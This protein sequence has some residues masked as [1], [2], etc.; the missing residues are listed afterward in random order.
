MYNKG[1]DNNRLMI[2]AQIAATNALN[3]FR[4]V[5]GGFPGNAVLEEVE[6][7]TDPPDQFWLITLSYNPSE[8]AGNFPMLYPASKEYKQ[9]KV[10]ASDGNVLSMKIR[11]ID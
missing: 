2:T 9:F 3:Y 10:N 4:A 11:K 8:R 5:T 1:G 6:M 7:L